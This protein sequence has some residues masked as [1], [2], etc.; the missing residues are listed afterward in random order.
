MVIQLNPIALVL[1]LPTKV[2]YRGKAE[3]ILT[4]RHRRDCPSA[5]IKWLTRAIP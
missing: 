5:D 4:P 2:G 3:A 1:I